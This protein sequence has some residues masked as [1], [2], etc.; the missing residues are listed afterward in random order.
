MV[1][2]FARGLSSDTY[3]R[4]IPKH[5]ATK[6]TQHKRNHYW[7]LSHPDDGAC[8]PTP[9]ARVCHSRAPLSWL[10]SVCPV[11]LAPARSGHA[12]LQTLDFA[13]ELLDDCVALLKILVEAVT[14][15]DELL[16]PLPETLFFDLDLLSESLA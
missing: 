16:F 15:A 12:A 4:S 10:P 2:G 13:L 5:D 3:A 9:S 6:E 14:L 1:K 8:H 11:S 7:Y